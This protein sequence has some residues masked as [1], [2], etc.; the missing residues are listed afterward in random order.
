[1]KKDVATDLTEKQV[2]AEWIRVNEEYWRLDDDQVKSTLKQLEKAE[3]SKTEIIQIEPE[4]GIHAIAFTF[5]GILE[6]F[7]E[8]IEEM[9]MESTCTSPSLHMIINDIS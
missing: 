9:A 6:D 3:G 4:A 2:Y 5:K 8:N 7:G 1:M